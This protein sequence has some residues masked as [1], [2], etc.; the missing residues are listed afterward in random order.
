MDFKEIL[1]DIVKRV[2]GGMAAVLMG[3]DG[4]SIDEYSIEGAGIDIQQI[5]VEYS[6]IL[7]ELKRTS[8]ALEGGDVAE[9]CVTTG[10][11][12]AVAGS[13]SAD[14]FLMVYLAPDGN[15]GKAR[16]LMKMAVPKLKEQL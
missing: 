13:L 2:D 11:G 9:V 1:K 16:Y 8:E 10:K 12:I 4:I 7:K 15:L 5:G 3:Y 6:S 14:Y